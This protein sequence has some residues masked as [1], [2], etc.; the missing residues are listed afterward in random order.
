MYTSV[1]V[2]WNSGASLQL[3]NVRFPSF[4][5]GRWRVRTSLLLTHFWIRELS[6]N[7]RHN[8]QPLNSLVKRKW[9]HGNTQG[10]MFA[11]AAKAFPGYFY[12]L[13][14]DVIFMQLEE[15]E[16]L[17]GY[18]SNA[19]PLWTVTVLNS[20]E[21]AVHSF[22]IYLAVIHRTETISSLSSVDEEILNIWL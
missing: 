17:T 8:T 22:I 15:S 9:I 3:V 5:S 6:Q 20:L 2:T 19:R 7:S 1:A 11:A 18:T 14:Y 12:N 21:D 13:S 16:R 10:R 4:L